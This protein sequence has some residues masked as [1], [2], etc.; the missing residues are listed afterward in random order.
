M[1]LRLQNAYERISRAIDTIASE[2]GITTKEAYRFAFNNYTRACAQP[3]AATPASAPAAAPTAAPT[4]AP[5]ASRGLYS[6]SIL[7]TTSVRTSTIRPTASQA[8]TH[9][10]DIAIVLSTAKKE[11]PSIPEWYVKWWYESQAA[12]DWVTTQGNRITPYTW[13]AFLNT[14]WT[15]ASEKERARIENE[16]KAA[17]SAAASAP[18]VLTAA[19]FAPCEAAHCMFYND[20]RHIC[21]NGKTPCANVKSCP[22]FRAS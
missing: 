21:S 4:A 19:D 5:A 20:E 15:N 1:N 13:R 11:M 6:D 10:L 17:Q 7:N 16:A 2:M 3:H 8:R 14:W 18:K 12:C 22:G 9:M